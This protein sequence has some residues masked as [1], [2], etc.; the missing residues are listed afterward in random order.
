MF[1]IREV[2]Q[3]IGAGWSFRIGASQREVLGAI[4]GHHQDVDAARQLDHPQSR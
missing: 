4:V 3:P 2:I 1:V